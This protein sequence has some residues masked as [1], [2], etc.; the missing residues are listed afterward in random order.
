MSGS[1]VLGAKYAVLLLVVLLLAVP[2]IA[3]T[4]N[5][6]DGTATAD[7]IRGTASSDRIRGLEG[8]DTLHGWAGD[9]RLVGGPGD[10][11]LNGG[12]GQD[13]YVCG[14]GEDMVVVEY[15]RFG[16]IEHFGDG[17]EAAIFDI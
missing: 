6:I 5:E 4:W 12:P 10:D 2:A 11:L 14:G 17:C 13:T 7:H 15:N 3:T 9:D 16:Q 1:I 8:D